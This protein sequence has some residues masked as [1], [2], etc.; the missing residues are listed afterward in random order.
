MTLQL[1]HS[2]DDLP[3]SWDG[4]PVEW[5]PWHSGASSADWHFP[6]SELACRACGVLEARQLAVGRIDGVMALVAFRC[7]CGRDEVHDH[8]TDETWVLCPEDYGPGGST[9]DGTLW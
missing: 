1:V 2:R 7:A 8:R 4:Q 6:P 9:P 5:G 3:R